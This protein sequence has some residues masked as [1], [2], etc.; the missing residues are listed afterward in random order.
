MAYL[1]KLGIEYEQAN[2]WMNK[3]K[4]KETRHGKKA[5]VEPSKAEPPDS[6]EERSFTSWERLARELNALSGYAVIL[7]NSQPVSEPF[8]AEL[9]RLTEK[10]GFKLEPREGANE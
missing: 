8:I 4:G 6:T 2:K 9:T 1:K 10:M 7:K 3:V 5:K